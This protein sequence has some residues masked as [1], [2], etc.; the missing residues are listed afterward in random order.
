MPRSR[1]RSLLSIMRSDVLCART[2]LD[3]LCVKSSQNVHSA[4]HLGREA[5]K[6]GAAGGRTPRARWGP[7]RAACPCAP[8]APTWFSRNTLDCLSMA[9][10]SVVLPWSTCAMM[11]MLRRSRR[12]AVSPGAAAAGAVQGGGAGEGARE[13]EVEDQQWLGVH[14]APHTGR[15]QAGRASRPRLRSK[16]A[17]APTLQR[18]GGANQLL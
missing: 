2:S 12:V 13:Q 18:G 9:S 6:K 14:H 4:G 17:A 1:S 8:W 16:Q 11:A 5:G 3:L 10:T 15:A 7:R